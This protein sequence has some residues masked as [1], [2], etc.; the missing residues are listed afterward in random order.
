MTPL[1]IAQLVLFFA[2]LLLLT[3]P[4]GRYLARVMEG[5]P[6]F[7]QRPLGWLERGTYRVLGV[8]PAQD[9]RWTTYA[10][11]MLAFSLV[12]MLFSYAVLRLQGLLPLNPQGFDGRQMPADLAFNVVNQVSF[13]VPDLAALRRKLQQL[14][15]DEKYEDAARVR[16][17]IR[18]LEEG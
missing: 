8:D 14:V 15:A 1:A 17:Q 12:S 13:R 11:S 2:V 7:L 16:D 10:V 9:M 18:R 6:I 5:E 3:R 4:L